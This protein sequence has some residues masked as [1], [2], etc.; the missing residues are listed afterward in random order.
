MHNLQFTK[1]K[2]MENLLY[3]RTDSTNMHIHLG[4]NGSI[5]L[6]GD[7]HSLHYDLNDILKIS[8]GPRDNNDGIKASLTYNPPGAYKTGFQVD[9]SVCFSI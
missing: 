5:T 6:D 9:R 1:Y 7:P 3:Y 4:Q 2:R 8:A